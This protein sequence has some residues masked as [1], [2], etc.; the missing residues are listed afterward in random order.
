MLVTNNPFCLRVE[1]KVAP[2][3]SLEVSFLDPKFVREYLR[4][5][6]DAE[7][8]AAKRRS[9]HDVSLHRSKVDILVVFLL[10]VSS[11]LVVYECVR[12]LCQGILLACKPTLAF[13]PPTEIIL[14]AL[15]SKETAHDGVCLFDEL[16]QMMIRLHWRLLEF[17]H[18]TIQFVDDEDRAQAVWPRLSQSRHRVK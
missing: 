2:E 8:P 4:K 15:A 13:L 3:Y 12:L 6:S 1:V 18:E 11:S 16:R 10:K 7:S 14:H 17:R 9:E 5:F